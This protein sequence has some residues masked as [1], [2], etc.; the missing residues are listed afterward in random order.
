MN[1]E[2]VE[3]FGEEAVSGGVVDKSGSPN[4]SCRDSHARITLEDILRFEGFP[5]DL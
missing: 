2:I 4:G 3:A 5:E 1:K